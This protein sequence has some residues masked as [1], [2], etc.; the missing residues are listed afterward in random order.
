[1]IF[2]R[3]ETSD[4]EK[5]AKTFMAASLGE[6]W[7]EAWTFEQAYA[8]VDELMASRMSRGFVAVKDGEIV[9]MCIGRVMTY[10]NFREFFV[11]DFNVHP[12]FQ[13]RGLG[14]QLLIFAKNQLEPERIGSF[15]LLTERDFPAR[16]FYEKNG[17]KVKDSLVFM[18]D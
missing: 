17:F 18:H 1:M 8:R 6:P 15:S 10:M 3:M 7:N 14:S 16:K 4:F 11:D 12:D 5:C 13:G 2:R 9:G